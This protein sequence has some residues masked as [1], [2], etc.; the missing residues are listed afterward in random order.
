MTKLHLYLRRW[1][2]QGVSFTVLSF[3]M[4]HIQTVICAFFLS[5]AHNQ[6]TKDHQR[7]EAQGAGSTST[8]EAVGA[9]GAQSASGSHSSTSTKPDSF[10]FSQ[11]KHEDP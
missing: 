10:S 6:F 1:N 5:A 4:S 9:S 7:E 8:P 3:V 2:I 11:G